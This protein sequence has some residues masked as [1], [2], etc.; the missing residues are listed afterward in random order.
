MSS[1][2]HQA[3]CF[4][5]ADSGFVKHA[6]AGPGGV[7]CSPPTNAFNALVDETL[8]STSKSQWTYGKGID[9]RGYRYV[10][11]Y[12]ADSPLFDCYIQ[13]Q[14]QATQAMPFAHVGGTIPLGDGARLQVEGGFMRVGIRINGSGSSCSRRYVVAG[15][16]E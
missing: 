16:Q 10:V 6:N 11:L 8:T 1:L 2:L 4:G 15:I 14:F 5:C 9:V 13:V 7:C 3:G 12:P